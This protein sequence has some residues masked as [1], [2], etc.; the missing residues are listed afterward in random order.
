MA[1]P[2]QVEVWKRFVGLIEGS[3]VIEPCENG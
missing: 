2:H 3:Q 1:V